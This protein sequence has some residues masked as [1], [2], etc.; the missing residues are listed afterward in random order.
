MVDPILTPEFEL[1][2]MLEQILI[3]GHPWYL[4]GV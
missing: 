1:P 4:L 3:D 2:K